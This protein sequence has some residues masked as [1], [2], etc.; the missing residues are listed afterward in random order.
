MERRPEGKIGARFQHERPHLPY[1]TRGP[2]ARVLETLAVP[3][4]CRNRPCK[5]SVQAW[6]RRQRYS[7]RCANGETSLFTLEGIVCSMEATLSACIEPDGGHGCNIRS[8]PGV[9]VTTW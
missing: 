4:A 6:P 9:T 8:R 2:K 7:K 5:Q 3:T 1:S